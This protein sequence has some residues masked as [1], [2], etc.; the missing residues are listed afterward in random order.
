MVASISARGG[1][2]AALGYYAH[3]SADNYYT[4]GSEPP[5]RWAGAAG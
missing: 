5:G 3:L 2:Q 1:A 4:C